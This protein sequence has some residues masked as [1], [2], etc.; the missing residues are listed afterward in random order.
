MNNNDWIEQLQSTM[1]HHQE[2]VPDALWADIEN[3]LPRRH[4]VIPQWL[5]YAA[6]AVVTGAVIGMGSLLLPT[7]HPIETS[8]ALGKPV[9]A[10]TMETDSEAL[11]AEVDPVNTRHATQTKP[12]TAQ[13]HHMASSIP[14]SPSVQ[15]SSQELTPTTTDTV[16]VEDPVQ[17]CSGDTIRTQP[18]PASTRQEPLYASVKPVLS[19]TPVRQLRAVTVS[20]YAT[21]QFPDFRGGKDYQYMIGPSDNIN[22]QDTIPSETESKAHGPAQSPRRAQD[23]CAEHHAPYSVGLSVSVP[24]STRLALTS[25]LVYTW[26]KSDFSTSEQTLHY[27]GV[28]LGVTYTLWQWRF[29]NLYA[30][31]AMQADFNVK[32]SVK[33]RDRVGNLDIGKDRVL[34][35]AMLGPGLQF[36]LNKDFGIYIEPTARFYF[37]NGSGV[38]NYFKDKPWNINF[39][40][41]L[42]L[43]LQ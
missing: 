18:R 10:Q 1:E 14:P 32:A 42:R 33:Q 39:N 38:L 25:G 2:P 12:T 43:T 37:N 22:P 8:P 17:T 15:S 5:R 29:V 7:S 4:K 26:Q 36:N 24:L 6:A 31:G 28:P 11:A 3:R 19:V 30:I 16:K 34:F 20:F 41:G 35:S 27:I 9:L 23:E 13:S 40:A 21:N